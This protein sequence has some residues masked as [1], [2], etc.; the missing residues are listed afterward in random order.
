MALKGASTT[1]GLLQLYVPLSIPVRA[2]RVPV[3]VIGPTDVFPTI[4]A[5]MDAEKL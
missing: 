3:N 1:E 4:P 2:S 5:S